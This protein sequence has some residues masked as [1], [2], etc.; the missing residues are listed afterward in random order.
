MTGQPMVTALSA[1]VAA[2]AAEDAASEPQAP[3]GA[4][5]TSASSLR[6]LWLPWPSPHAWLP[7]FSPAVPCLDP[8]V[9]DSSGPRAVLPFRLGLSPLPRRK[10][11]GA[12]APHHLGPCQPQGFWIHG[13]GLHPPSSRLC[14]GSDQVCNWPAVQGPARAQA[15]E[16]AALGTGRGRRTGTGQP[17]RMQAWPSLCVLGAAGA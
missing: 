12:P 13:L 17:G 3:P 7:S 2:S 15:Q 4:L 5:A 11:W 16:P 14:L 8:V 9:Q 6:D 1:E 10:F